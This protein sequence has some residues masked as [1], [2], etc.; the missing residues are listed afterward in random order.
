M[1]AD[2]ARP[3]RIEP[4]PGQESVWDYPRPPR[5][6][7]CPD[8]VVVRFAGLDLAVTTR[9]LR[10]LETSQAPAFYLPAADVAVEHLVP[11]AST[12]FCEWKGQASY[13]D[14]Q[15]GDRRA[16]AAVWTYPAPSPGFV[17]IADTWPSTRA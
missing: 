1:L 12:T 10:V 3:V 8:R 15:V 2:M 11:A 17:A 9:A 4:G 6:E 7:P 13:F 14:V 16:A 5:V